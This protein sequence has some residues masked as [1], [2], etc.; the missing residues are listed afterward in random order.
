MGIAMP[1]TNS[2][3]PGPLLTREK[4]REGGFKRYFT[5]MPCSKGHVSQ[6]YTSIGMCCECQRERRLI[7]IK[8]RAVENERLKIWRK[9]NPNRCREYNK[10]DVEKHGD[11]RRAKI[12]E[13]ELA[14]PEKVKVSRKSNEHMRRSSVGKFTLNDIKRIGKAQKWKC[15][16]CKVS[17]KENYN[18]DHILAIANGGSNWPA[19][20]Q[21][22]CRTCNSRKHAKDPMDFAR[23]C[24]K[25][26]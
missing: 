11:R 26:L 23:E 1:N 7:E 21:L 25:L 8:D 4:A 6:R 18:I 10:R 9:K 19:N 15:A 5:G 13:W 12:K 2:K 17:V 14:N 20:L 24:G 22:T 3:Y 16:Y